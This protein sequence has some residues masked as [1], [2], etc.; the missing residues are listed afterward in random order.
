MNGDVVKMVPVPEGIEIPANGKIEIQPGGYHIMLIGLKRELK[1]GDQF[2]ITLTFENTP[3]AV[4]QVTV[5][6]S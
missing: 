6:E 3:P 5:K 4:I 2:E 1:P